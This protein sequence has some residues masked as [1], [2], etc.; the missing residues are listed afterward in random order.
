MLDTRSDWFAE[1]RAAA[2]H[3]TEVA[4]RLGLGVRRQRFGP[5]PACGRDDRNHPSVTARHGGAG[6]MCAGCKATG[7]VI[8]LAAW[9][10]TGTA[11]PAGSSWGEV[12][13]WF[14]A[15][16]W[17]SGDGAVG[18][19]VA[20]PRREV[21]KLPYPDRDELLS[22]LRACRPV[23]DV[24]EVK[25][26]CEARGIVGRVHGAVLPD[27]HPWPA[28]WPFRARPWRLVCPM[29]DAMGAVTSIHAR[30]TEDEGG[31]GKTRCPFERRGDGLF[32]ADPLVARPMLRAQ[33]TPARV[34][35]V[36]GITDY[37][38]AARHATQDNGGTAVLGGISGSFGAMAQACIPEAATVYA[39]T[40]A[41]E[42]GDRYATEIAR[43]L[44]G[45]DVRRI[46]FRRTST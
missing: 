8:Q 37:L 44:K 20:P 45:R 12:R 41:D 19:W 5:C 40:D 32:F 7:D 35:V 10:I 46:D 1:V 15:Q 31:R 6:W 25:A 22:L 21:P 13:S 17:C 29:V 27:V 26:W 2:P 42:A 23:E 33:A 36:E 39:W 30:A 11:R 34:V 43:A 3:V 28:W 14:A 24:R 16:G 4:E 38:A 9:R 18:S